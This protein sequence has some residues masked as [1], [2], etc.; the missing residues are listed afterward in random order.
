MGA[1]AAL[2]AVALLLYYV[3]HVPVARD[4]DPTPVQVDDE[5]ELHLRPYF[6]PLDHVDPAARVLPLISLEGVENEG[7]SAR[8]DEASL[9]DATIARLRMFND[10]LVVTRGPMTWKTK[11]R[12]AGHTGIDIGVLAPHGMPEIVIRHVGEGTHPGFSL[13][14]RNAAL[15]VQLAVA[16]DPDSAPAEQKYL[17]IGQ[18]RAITVAGVLPISVIVPEGRAVTLIFPVEN[19]KSAFR[20]GPDGDKS[21]AESRLGLRDLGVLRHD[22]HVFKAYFCAARPGAHFFPFFLRNLSS[23][24][25]IGPG[26]LHASHFKL[27]SNGMTLSVAGS[28]FHVNDGVA[29]TDDWFSSMVES[30]K[31]LASLCGIAIAALASWGVSRIFARR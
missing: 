12:G 30:N 19:P 2:L 13:T 29:Q 20:L 31:L 22:A 4:Q 9:D 1:L 21:A 18:A 26:L 5:F 3:T 6:D 27:S 23:D 7:V 25:C 24:D 8:F 17:Q 11:I 10:E 28:A 16:L 14:A 15:R